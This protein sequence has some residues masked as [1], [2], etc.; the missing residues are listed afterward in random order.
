MYRNRIIGLLFLI[1]LPILAAFFAVFLTNQLVYRDSAFAPAESYWNDTLIQGFSCAM[2]PSLLCFIVYIVFF[3]VKKKEYMPAYFGKERPK[4][5]DKPILT[6]AQVISELEAYRRSWREYL[7]YRVRRSKYAQGKEVPS[8]V[9]DFSI[10]LRTTGYSVAVIVLAVV[11]LFYI[12]KETVDRYMTIFAID[13]VSSF[14]IGA[15]SEEVTHLLDEPYGMGGNNKYSS[16]KEIWK[17][18]DDEYLE[19]L[20]KNNRFDPDDIEDM[21]DLEDAFNDSL[22]VETSI[23]EYIE[24]RFAAASETDYETKYYLQSIFYDAKRTQKNSDAK[25]TIDKYEII[26]AEIGTGTGMANVI[27]SVTYTDGSYLK[28]FAT[29][30]ADSETATETEVTVSWNDRFGNKLK[31]AATCTQTLTP[32]PWEQTAL[33][34]PRNNPSF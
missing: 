2:I 25:K 21:D 12:V 16:S 13:I 6:Y 23:F 19:I 17:Y 5:G 4:R 32:L 26:S 20:K 31:T 11:A 24:V 1:I 3:Q 30:V 29:A 22:K 9:S 8:K 15:T 14:E 27:Y 34:P 28:A 7:E 18:Y 10:A 33:L